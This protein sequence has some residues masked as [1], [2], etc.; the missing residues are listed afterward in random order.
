MG[1]KLLNIGF[2]NMIAANRA[3]AIISPESAPIKR[4]I[5]DA[6]DKGLLIDATYGRKTRA[7]LVMDSGHV[8]LSAIQPETVSHR[9]I[10]QD[11]V[12]ETTEA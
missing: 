8:V 12:E 7:V 4:M 11:A 5:Q 1:I 2:G 9:I 3:I 6:K 10:Q